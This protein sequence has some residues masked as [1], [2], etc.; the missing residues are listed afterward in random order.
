MDEAGAIETTGTRIV[1]ENRWMRLRED[2]ILRRDGSSG[3]YSVV[4]KPDFVVV[5]PV[6]ADGRL[7]L[8]E[9]FRY[10]VQGRYWEFPQGS[11]EQTP[12][13]D[14]LDIARGELR[15]ETGLEADELTYAGHLL[16]ACGYSNQG[17]HIFVATG[18]RRGETA[19]APEEQ[20]LVAGSFALVEVER[21]I[22]DGV[23]KDA[24]TVAVLGLLRLK[25]ML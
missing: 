20:D 21:M 13:A 16:E 24:T 22:C 25:G 5:V 9:Q 4:E 18:L 11:W 2:T 10:P 1:Y 8:V 17:Y 15:E 3:I 23:I 14:P 6:E 12:G 7:H 19:L